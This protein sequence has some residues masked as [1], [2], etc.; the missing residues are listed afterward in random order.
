[1]L[2]LTEN[3]KV[4]AIASQLT[5]KNKPPLRKNLKCGLFS[6]AEFGSELEVKVG[7]Y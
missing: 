5:T 2:A 7:T 1:M 3:A 4:E 6:Y